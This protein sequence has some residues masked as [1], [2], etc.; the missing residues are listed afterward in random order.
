MGIMGFLR[1]RAGLLVV[2]AIGFALVAFLLGEII[3]QL[4][5]TVG[6]NQNEVGKID[7]ES[8]DY[9]SFNAEVEMGVNNMRQQMGGSV[10]EQMNAY[11]IENVWNQRVSRAL[12]E[13]EIERI[14]LDVG[15]SELNDL[16]SGQ[17]P[18]PQIVQSFTNP[19][20]G[21]F[22]R[23]SLSVFLT[24]IRNEP[25]NSEQK[26]QWEN[27][28][29]AIKNDRLQQKYNQLIQNSVYVTSLEAN[30]DYVQRNKI[31]NFSYVLMDYASVND[32]DIQLSEED[33][34]NY[35]NENKGLFKNPVE[36]RSIEYVA[37]NARPT[38][39]D[40]AAVKQKVAELAAEFA[41][42]DNDSLFASI[43][44][45]T[46]YPVMYYSEGQ[47]SPALDSA[48]FNASAGSVVGPLYSNGT[49]EM[50][51]VID[52]RMSPDSVTA[53]H[54]LLNPAIEGGLPQA[55]AKADSI[56]NLLQ[57]GADFT[58]LALTHSTDATKNDGGKLGTF[59]RGAIPPIE[60]AVF[61]GRTG[62]ILVATTQYGVHIIRIDNQKGSSRVVKAAIID[63]SV[64]S[65]KETMNE[66]YAKAS[67]FFGKV[68]GD[69]FSEVAKSEGYQ[70]R[71]GEN[72]APMQ[73]SFEDI[74]SPREIIRW[75]FDAKVG[76]VSEKVFELENQ[77][78]VAR[79]KDVRKAGI[80]PLESVKNDI[81][82]A[83]LNRT[84]AKQLK[85]KTDAALQGTS[86]IAQVAQKLGKSPVK[87]EN[88][89][90]ANPIIP[91]VAQENRVVGTVFGLQ[92]AALSKSIEGNQGV[93][94]VAVQDFVNPSQPQ[95]LLSIKQ[96]NLN[97]IKQRVPG[98]VYQV[99]QDNAEIED[100]R[101]RFY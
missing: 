2:W 57:N 31:A 71:V 41:T 53:S 79:V 84:K 27:F 86:N 85:E 37:F 10:N 99:L 101:V 19:E 67:A 93:Y 76:D 63:R 23:N 17:N 14:G 54:I 80:L 11:V 59:A 92:P 18:S 20:T 87:V 89:V 43:N 36:T 72:I 34:K 78:V 61:N 3:P 39:A 21:Q 29:M 70:V 58:E 74:S 88:I 30:E 98:A 32:K 94:V 15:S 91:G 40:S 56:K 75:A 64:Q 46:K 81:Q 55:Q 68:D 83:V 69:N 45:E 82:P 24:N 51:K 26:Q 90:F 22:D 60:D 100:N 50:A 16:V 35:Y 49:Y 4:A 33:Y 9:A 47:L 12:L 52:S 7:G 42:A 25:A 6:P 48:L 73:A 5:G 97:V 44:S 77:Y 66:A 28:L 96:Q 38:A 8:I 95:N 62:D 13:K 1:N 65:S